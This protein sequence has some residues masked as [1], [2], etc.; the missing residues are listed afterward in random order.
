MKNM[1]TSICY[2]LLIALPLFI[3]SCSKEGPAGPAGPAG[4][5]GTAG[6]AGPAGPAGAA[7]AAGTANVIYSTWL[8]V[9]F[10]YNVDPANPGDTVWS[11][12]LNVPKL[13]AAILNSGDVKVYFN[14]GTSATPDV[15]P[16][17]LL[18]PF[19]GYNLEI[20][21]LSIQNITFLSNFNA[22]FRGT[23]ANKS[24]Q[25]RYIL[26]PGGTP[27]RIMTDGNKVDWNDY[28]SVQKYLGLTD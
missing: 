11:A 21:S 5:Q 15:N 3:I 7:G 14:F 4:P 12:D 23:G 16:L 10:T 22:S 13:T 25:F 6:A 17:P 28:A 26:I 1:K 27:A 19:L 20:Y 2:V 24:Y 9:P 18:S 8:D